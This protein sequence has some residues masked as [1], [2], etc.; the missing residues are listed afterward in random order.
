MFTIQP[1]QSHRGRATSRE[2]WV[3]GLVDCSQRPALGYMEIVPNRTAATLLPIIQGHVWP[4]TTV[5]SDEWSAY[6]TVQGL[7]NVQTYQTVN[8]SLHFVNPTTGVHTQN[9]ESYWARVKLKFK[10]MK[11]V[12]ADQLPSYLDEFMW[13]E[14]HGT[15]AGEAFNNILDHIADIY[16]V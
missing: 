5:H 16:P 8:H 6:R 9:V 3:F 11:G 14:R 10:R 1:Q 13:R 4:G 12:D 7:P 2:I 15:T